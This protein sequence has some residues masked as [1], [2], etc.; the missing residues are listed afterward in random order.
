MSG[1]KGSNHLPDPV[2]HPARRPQLAHPR[3]HQWITRPATLPFLQIASALPPWKLRK[4]LA[5]RRIRS[6]GEMKKKMVG[7]LAPANFPQ[8]RLYGRLVIIILPRQERVPD[9]PR[10]DLAKMQVRRQT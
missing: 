3:I 4:L 5:K 6:G 7:K 10:T 9:L 2:V 1:D 8:V